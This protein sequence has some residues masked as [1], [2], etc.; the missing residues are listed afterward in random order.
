MKKYHL[1][2]L[3]MGQRPERPD[4]ARADSLQTGHLVYLNELYENRKASLIGPTEDE[5]GELRGI[6]VYN[7]PTLA[8]ADSLARLDPLVRAGW[9]R[10]EIFPWWTE[11]GA[12]LF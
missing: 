3:K 12:R 1:C 2:L 10:V 11:A 6:V 9:L 8:E 5:T 4:P 7:T